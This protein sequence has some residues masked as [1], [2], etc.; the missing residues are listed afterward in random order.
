MKSFQERKLDWCIVITQRNK[1][2][3]LRN[4]DLTLKEIERLQDFSVK[5]KSD[6]CYSLGKGNLEQLVKLTGWSVQNWIQCNTGSGD[7]YRSYCSKLEEK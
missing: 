4:M 5:D 7:S 2:D 6:Q 3:T 1:S